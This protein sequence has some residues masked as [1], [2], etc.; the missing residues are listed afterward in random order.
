MTHAHA[1]DFYYNNA[2]L[3][4]LNVTSGQQLMGNVTFYPNV[5]YYPYYH[6]PQYPTPCPT[7]GHCPTCGNQPAQHGHNFTTAQ[8]T[9]EAK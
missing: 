2:T 7:C 4:P 6:W 3:Q 5:P 1:G 8:N 9:D